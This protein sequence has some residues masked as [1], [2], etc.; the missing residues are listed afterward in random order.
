MKIYVF[1]LG[2][3]GSNLIVQ[4]MKQFPDFEYFGIDYDK[5]EERNIKTQA[6]FLEQVG[7]PKAQAIPIISSRFL[8]KFKYTPQNLKVETH[9][10]KKYNLKDKDSLYI[11]CFDNSKSRKFL[12]TEK[13]DDNVLHIGFSPFYSSEIMWQKDY[14]VPNDVDQR[15]N[16]ICSM[17]DAVSFINFIVNYSVLNISE[18][19]NKGIKSSYII[20]NKTKIVKIS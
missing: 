17:N 7:M 1:G 8:R 16:D 20:T 4:L 3:I 19:I 18:Y 15:Q 10:S 13:S 5:I 6:F 11:D 2:A 14:D 9:I 12:F